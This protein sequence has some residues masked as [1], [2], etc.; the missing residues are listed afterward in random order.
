M[1]EIKDILKSVCKAS[2]SIRL[3]YIVL[4]KNASQKFF[5]ERGNDI[6]NPIS[7]TLVNA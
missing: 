7:G 5:I 1:Q 4:D 3:T 6:S 2:E